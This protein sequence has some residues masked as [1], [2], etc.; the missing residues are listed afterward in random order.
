MI[1]VFN[2]SCNSY[3]GYVNTSILSPVGKPSSVNISCTSYDELHSLEVFMVM[4]APIDEYDKEFQRVIKRHKIDISKLF[5]KNF[6]YYLTQPILDAI[7]DKLEFKIEF[8][9]QKVSNVKVCST[10]C[11]FIC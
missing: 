9:F 2:F 6:A 4:T 8:P 7:L 10:N 5:E 1:K 3:F 11:F